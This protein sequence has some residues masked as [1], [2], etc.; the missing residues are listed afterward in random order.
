MITFGEWREGGKGA[1]WR[2]DGPDLEVC[3]MLEARDDEGVFGTAFV[4]STRG[5]PRDWII[6]VETSDQVFNAEAPTALEAMR[7]AMTLL[8]LIIAF[9]KPAAARALLRCMWEARHGEDA[10]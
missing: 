10:G 9:R 7:T 5:K 1:L 6:Q 3:K 2:T 4:G 8:R